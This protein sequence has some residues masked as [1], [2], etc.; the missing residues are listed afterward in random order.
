MWVTQ[1]ITP[2]TVPY[3]YS[4]QYTVYSVP[5]IILYSSNLRNKLQKIQLTFRIWYTVLNSL[6]TVGLI[7]GVCKTVGFK[8]LIIFFLEFSSYNY[9]TSMFSSVSNVRTRLS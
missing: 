8:V 6:Y 1:N 3:H 7:I 5:S 4:I 9:S 2:S